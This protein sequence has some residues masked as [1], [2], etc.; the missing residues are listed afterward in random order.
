MIS[1]WRGGAQFPCLPPPAR[2]PAAR[3][4]KNNGDARAAFAVS[5]AVSSRAASEQP[6][7]PP[8]LHPGQHEHDPPAA[9]RLPP[10][11]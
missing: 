6:P 5:A 10:A 4:Q 1:P 2:I 3:S 11:S 7:T 9:P 8:H